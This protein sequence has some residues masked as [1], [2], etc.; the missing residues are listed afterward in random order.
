V[1]GCGAG[2]PGDESASKRRQWCKCVP[3]TSARA[4]G[5]HHASALNPH[6]FRH[7]IVAGGRGS[8]PLHRDFDISRA[9]TIHNIYAFPCGWPRRSAPTQ[10]RSTKPNSNHQA[11][12]PTRCVVGCGAGGPGDESG[13]QRRQRCQ[14]VP[15]TSARARGTHHASELKSRTGVDPHHQIIH[16]QPAGQRDAW[17]DVE[18][19]GRETKVLASVVSGASV[20]R[21]L[22]HEREAPTT[23][24]H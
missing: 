7:F 10:N 21:R 12:R 6:P 13:S 16:I 4:R 15:A 20:Y 1:V 11:S 18:R 2:G 3:A 22:R 23:R 24:A 8:P 5:T 19:E 9:C 17:W 14:C